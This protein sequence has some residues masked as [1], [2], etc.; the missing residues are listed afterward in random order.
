MIVEIIIIVLVLLA[1]AVYVYGF[2]MI[3]DDIK[4]KY[5]T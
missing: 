5:E 2:K 4:I 1:L 3:I